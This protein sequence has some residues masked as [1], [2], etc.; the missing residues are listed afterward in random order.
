MSSLI[1]LDFGYNL[2][3]ELLRTL[4]NETLGSY[5]FIP[6]VGEV[7]TVFVHAMADLRTCLRKQTKIAIETEGTIQMPN[8]EKTS[9]GYFLHLGQ[10]QKG[11]S[12]KIEIECNKPIEVSILDVEIETISDSFEALQSQKMAAIIMKCHYLSEFSEGRVVEYLET[13]INQL[14]GKSPIWPILTDKSERQ[15][16][17]QISKNGAS[18]ICRLLLVVTNIKMQ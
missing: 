4:S 2:D 16:N 12:R 17:L 10:L 8:L 14:I 11:Y 7:G 1:R 9:W 15:L 6:T 5:S 13:M 18:T 3:S